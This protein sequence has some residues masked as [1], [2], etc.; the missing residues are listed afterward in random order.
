MFRRSLLLGKTTRVKKA[1]IAT[2]FLLLS[3][4]ASA[5]AQTGNASLGGTVSDP[6]N[7]L[8][9]GVTVTATNVDTNIVQTTISNETG[10]Y[11]FPVLQPGKY[12]VTADLPGFK[13]AVY[14][15]VA[16]PYAGQIRLNFTLQVGT[17]STIV[18]VNAAATSVIRDSSASVGDVLTQSAIQNLPMVGNNVL[19]LLT[20]LPGF[21]QDPNPG[22]GG[23]G[24]NNSVNGLTMDSVN[25]TRDGISV[26]D[27]RN[28]TGTYGM[29]SLSTTV[30]L[31]ELVGEIRMILA[32][33]DAE[34][35]RGNSQIQIATRSGTNRYTGSASWNA[36]NS[37]LNANTWTNNHTPFTDP[38]SGE[39][40]PYT[41]KTWNNRHQWTVA[42]G[43]PIKIPG[44]YDGKNKTFFYGVVS[45]NIRNTREQV[46]GAT[47]LTATARQGIYRY[48]SGYNPVG[49]N[50]AAALANPVYPMTAT[51]A[52]LIAVNDQGVPIK[53]VA[54]PTSPT[55]DPNGAGFIPYSGL[56][57]WTGD[58]THG[59][60]RVG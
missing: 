29:N 31:P 21:R 3:F 4:T 20:T 2:A 5:F 38:F 35:G 40:T 41:P 53:P 9:P 32:P 14:T 46:T 48:W 18:E 54:A 24:T 58:P 8:I 7:A 45:Q 17:A 43:G 49:W 60:R 26:N 50:P 51:T 28:S 42:Y 6:S 47:V 27:M 19:D 23:G 36:M 10:S 33:V 56:S 44:V 34:L 15:D 12:K 37:A 55:G 52:S 25:A 57:R 22:L 30:I 1:L 13:Q 59:P 16:L 11:S 39:R